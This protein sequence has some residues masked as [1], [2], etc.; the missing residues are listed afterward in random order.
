MFLKLTKGFLR[1][2]SA[3]YLIPDGKK[4]I[5]GIKIE[6]EINIIVTSS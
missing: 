2:K 1:R 6:A 4:H 3:A 5:S